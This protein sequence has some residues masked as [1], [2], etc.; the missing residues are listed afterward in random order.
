MTYSISIMKKIGACIACLL[1]VSPLMAQDE[2]STQYHPYAPVGFPNNAPQWMER[3][4]DVENVNYYA[5]VDSFNA[6]RNEHPEMRRKTP[7]TKAV[8]NY[9][10]RWQKTYR[11]YVNKEGR[12]VLPSFSHYRKYVEDM[13]AQSQQKLAK[14]GRAHV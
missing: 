13:N 8:I 7:M 3:L 14:I 5:M 12:I 9:F 10:K 4:T 1:A 6:F 2:A 11:P